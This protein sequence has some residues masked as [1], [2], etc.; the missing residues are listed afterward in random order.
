MSWFDALLPREHV[1][2]ACSINIQTM[3]PC[4]LGIRGTVKE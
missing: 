4:K 3:T 2:G 1:A